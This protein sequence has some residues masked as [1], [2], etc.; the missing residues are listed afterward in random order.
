VNKVVDHWSRWKRKRKRLI[1]QQR[2]SLPWQQSSQLG[3]CKLDPPFAALDSL[4]GWLHLPLDRRAL[5]PPFSALDLRACCICRSIGAHLN[6]R[7]PCTSRLL[8][9]SVC[10]SINA[11]L[12]LRAPVTPLLLSRLIGISQFVL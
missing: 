7:S 10:S 3:Q 1:E 12:I 8:A 11:H 9:G 4:A 5:G 6:L 2:A